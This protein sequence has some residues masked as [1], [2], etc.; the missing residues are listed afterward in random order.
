MRDIKVTR[1]TQISVDVNFPVSGKAKNISS[2]GDNTGTPWIE[3]IINDRSFGW[4]ERILSIAGIVPNGLEENASQSQISEAIEILIKI[5]SS[6]YNAVG[7]FRWGLVYTSD[8]DVGIYQGKAYKYVGG[9][10]YPVTVPANTVDPSVASDYEEAIYNPA[11]NINLLDGGDLQ[12]QSDAK[13]GLTLEEAINYKGI[14]SLIGSRVW[15]T[16]RQAW[17]DVVLSSSFSGNGDGMDELTSAAN[18]TY[19]LK[20]NQ[21]NGCVTLQSLGSLN[22]ESIDSTNQYDRACELL[23]ESDFNGGVVVLPNYDIYMSKLTL[24]DHIGIKGYGQDVS[25]ILPLENTGPTGLQDNNYGFVEQDS[26]RVR[27]VHLETFSVWG[28]TTKVNSDAPRNT[29]Q[30]AMY[31]KATY[32]PTTNDGGLWDFS[33]KDVRCAGWKYGLWSRGGYTT[34][35][36]RL[37][38]QFWDANKLSII[39][40]DITGEPIRMTGQ[41]GQIA[42]TGNGRAEFAFGGSVSDNYNM[43]IDWDPN[44][45]EVVNDGVN[46]ESDSDVSGTGNAVRTPSNV[47]FKDGFVVQL[48]YGV[49]ARNNKGCI[50]NGTW[51]ENCQGVAFADST[52]HIALTNCH[53]ASSGQNTGGTGYIQKVGSNA[54]VDWGA[55]NNIFGGYDS[56]FES[57]S[58]TQRKSQFSHDGWDSTDGQFT[59]GAPT[60]AIANDIDVKGNQY[61]NINCSNQTIDLLNID[62]TLCPSMHLHL[63]VVNGNLRLRNTG[64]VRF[65]TGFVST[66]VFPKNSTV[67][68]VRAFDTKAWNL[69]IPEIPFYSSAEPSDGYYYHVGTIIY[70]TSAG[71]GQPHGWK[72]NASGLAGTT[73][74]FNELGSI[75]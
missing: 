23:I 21:L 75:Q 43:K 40:S 16:D 1:P 47:Q 35:H 70:N 4:Q 7:S 42:F 25:N 29:N 33:T 74:T 69:V 48:G 73:A 65:P 59:T 64:N 60:I 63:K 10:S 62:S 39:V 24:R 5:V 31:L 58:N 17:F 67:T 45:S 51:F 44:P 57:V 32:D 15:I 11:S 50:L 13:D 55:G 46:G 61:V 66:K 27:G 20:L 30:W 6:G 37:P 18:A 36:S 9:D 22:D 38:Q 28:N 52:G 68:L 41:H 54:A 2:A 8:N 26:G 14:A 3:D 53:I 34:T 56:L 12:S 19:G 49:Y 71:I 72:C